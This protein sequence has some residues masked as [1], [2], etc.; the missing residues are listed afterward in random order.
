MLATLYP[1]KSGLG[2]PKC[3]WWVYKRLSIPKTTSSFHSVVDWLSFLSIYQKR[4]RFPITFNL[5]IYSFQTASFFSSP[6][7]TFLNS[8]GRVL[9]SYTKVQIWSGSH[10]L[11]RNHFRFASKH[12]KKKITEFCP[13][14]FST[15]MFYWFVFFP[16]NSIL[17]TKQSWHKQCVM[18]D[19]FNLQKTWST[20]TSKGKENLADSIYRC[21][22]QDAKHSG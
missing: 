10:H 13:A 4:Q 8:P 5:M 15:G 18:K 22:V 17:I 19:N 9:L 16:Y 6:T 21:F 11:Y 3:C 1:A 7:S 20:N 14:L 2:K 12:R